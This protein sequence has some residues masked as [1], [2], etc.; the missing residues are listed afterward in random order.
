MVLEN[1]YSA[2]IDLAQTE[3]VEDL[4]VTENNGVLHITGTTNNTTKDKL[5]DMYNKI[6]PDMRAGD[7][8]LDLNVDDSKKDSDQEMYEVKAGDSLS[9]IASRYSGM[10]WKEIYEA[11]KDTIKDPNIIHPGQK[12]KIPR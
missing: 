1:K 12:I 7:L 8:V 11:N 5:W 6:D 3:K 4:S 2:L 9:K 10:T